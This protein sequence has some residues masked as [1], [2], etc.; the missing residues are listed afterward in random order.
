M[1]G[2][3]DRNMFWVV[4]DLTSQSLRVPKNSNGGSSAPVHPSFRSPWTTKDLV[5]IAQIT[6]A[7]LVSLEAFVRPNTFAVADS[8]TA[9]DGTIGWVYIRNDGM[10]ESI[11]ISVRAATR[12]LALATTWE[13]IKRA[14]DEWKYKN[15]DVMDD[16]PAAGPS[17]P[18]G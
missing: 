12:H 8:R 10:L 11:R 5:E 17:S 9:T 14:W 6:T 15:G 7:D 3:T 2:V 18:Q 13:E 1:P 4:P 16:I